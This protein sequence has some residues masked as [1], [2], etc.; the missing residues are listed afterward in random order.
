[1]VSAFRSLQG[2]FLWHLNGDSMTFCCQHHL[3]GVFSCFIFKPAQIE[4]WQG[5][6]SKQCFFTFKGG[7]KPCLDGLQE[8]QIQ[9]DYIVYNLLDMQLYHNYLIYVTSKHSWQKWIKKIEFNLIYNNTTYKLHI[10]IT[11]ALPGLWSL[12]GQPSSGRGPL[13]VP[14]F[15][16]SVIF[17]L[18]YIQCHT[19]RLQN[20][21]IF[22]KKLILSLCYASDVQAGAKLIQV[23]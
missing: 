21:T 2:L 7:S 17:T 13:L 12:G 20:L 5:H 8:I 19:D 18:K 3:D 14:R 9:T 6:R 10:T 11:P 4:F 22:F 23:H 16:P 15:W 1:M